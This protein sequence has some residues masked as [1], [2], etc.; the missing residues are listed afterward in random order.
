M[1]TERK[2]LTKKTQKTINLT[3]EKHL[4]QIEWLFI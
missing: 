3:L 4:M 2:K 1:K